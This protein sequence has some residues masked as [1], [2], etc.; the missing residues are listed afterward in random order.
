VKQAQ[1]SPRLG[2]VSATGIGVGSMLGAGVFVVWSPAAHAAGAW[3]PISVVIA[4]TIA[5]INALS[6]AHLAALHPVAGGAYTY[7]RRELRG[8]WGFVAGAGFVTGKTASLAAMGLAIGSHTAPGHAQWVATAVLIGAWVLNA[9]G[10]NRTAAVTTLVAVIVAVGLLALAGASLA[11]PAAPA[12]AAADVGVTGVAEG[13]ALVFFAFAGYARLATLG[14]D[15]RDP[16]RVI[17][18][19][20]AVAVGIVVAIYVLLAFVVLR[21]PGASHLADVDAPLAEA[22]P[23]GGAWPH[24]IGLLAVAAAGG[25]LVA[26]LAGVGRTAMAMARGGD[27]PTVLAHRNRKDVPVVAEGVAASAAIAL[28]WWGNVGFAIAMS[29]AAV[30]AYYAVSNAA[31]MAAR[32]RGARMPVPPLLSGL[33]AAVCVA[34]AASLEPRALAAAGAVMAVTLLGRSLRRSRGGRPQA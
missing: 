30:L 33:G 32:R 29:S 12:A 26:L 28:V 22:A 5:V 3:L 1:P 25:A 13:A 16:E 15:V 27:V 24:V 19:A 7:G 20:V 11:A 31:A 10:V 17:P 2:L 23:A 8:P 4:A 34:L 18:R 14:E 9:M 6:T 21:R